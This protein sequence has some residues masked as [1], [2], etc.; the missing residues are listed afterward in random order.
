M[1]IFNFFFFFLTIFTK[2]NKQKNTQKNQKLIQRDELLLFC[3]KEIESWVTQV[4][5]STR[6]TQKRNSSVKMQ[7][8][9]APNTAGKIK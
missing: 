8:I 9:I 7:I 3:W 5:L 1:Q 6:S 2:A 4:V